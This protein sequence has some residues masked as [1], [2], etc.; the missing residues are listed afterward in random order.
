MLSLHRWAFFIPFCI[1]AS[2]AFILSLH[3]PRT[4]VA[5]TSFER[6]ND[7]ILADLRMSPGAATFKLFRTTIARDLTSVGCMTEVVENIGLTKDFDRNEDGALTGVSIRRRNTL[8]L[9]LG[10]RIRITTRRPNEEVD[11]I[12]ITYT[13]PDP[14]IGK[15]LL[16]EVKATYIRRTMAWVQQ[17][18]EG[19]R[20]YY[21][22]ETAEARERLREVEREQTRL[23]LEN[24]H[25]N[26]QNP[27]GISA[28]L[29]QLE[30]EKHE[31]LRR[32]REYQADLD[33]QKQML[34][35][36]EA[37]APQRTVGADP[38]DG[39]TKYISPDAA[40]LMG[41]IAGITKKVE[42]LKATRGMTDQHPEIR[43]LRASRRWREGELEAQNA[44]DRQL[45]V[46]NEALDA[47]GPAVSA[48]AVGLAEPWHSD[49]VQLLAQI[50]AQNN[51]IKD[52]TISLETSER[53]IGRLTEAKDGIY[54][55]QEEYADV[56]ARVAEAR[57]DHNSLAAILAKVEPAIKANQQNKLLHWSVGQP[58]RGGNTPVNPKARTVVLLA[59]LAGVATGVV[60]VILAEILD[61]VY[62]S[63]GQVARSLGLPILDAIDDIV[64]AQDRRRI[65]IRKTVV[66]PL[67]VLSCLGLIGV[68]GSLAYLS[69][70]RPYTF[71]PHRH[72]PRSAPSGRRSEKT[73]SS[74]VGVTSGAHQ[75]RRFR[76]AALRLALGFG[77]CNGKKT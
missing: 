67:I 17:H 25:I 39:E 75:A 5:K 50:A 18:L 66:T 72:R 13:G 38:G 23:R 15:K 14:G 33:A 42:H 34:A 53:E 16:N 44:R 6:R 37:Q 58:A 76:V 61:H 60:F 10:E 1:V 71:N 55:L 30:M 12:D 48:L 20:E 27:G 74:L 59:L 29:S 22:V 7:P 40:R 11:I 21:S 31:L 69:I 43:E 70:Q 35:S 54:E 47:A 62:R 63:S 8:A 57:R 9:S 49:R 64:T 73:T 56:S 46:A 45:T 51:K 2:A 52:V 41:L 77:L 26:P 3:Y 65:L 28:R 36:M 32:R 24:P 4:Y 19:L 68:T